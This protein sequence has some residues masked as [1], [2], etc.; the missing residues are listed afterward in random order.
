MLK[1]ETVFDSYICVSASPQNTINLEVPI[2]ALQR[3]LKSAFGA[4]SAQIRLTKKDN[5]PM[6]SLTIVTS[7]FAHGNGVVARPTVHNASGVD[8]E[9]G[10]FDFSL[11]FEEEGFGGSLRERETIVTQD[12]PVKVLTMQTV[13]GLLEPRTQ[14]PDVHIYL[15]NLAQV[16]SISERF[17]RL[18][19]TSKSGSSTASPRLELSANMHGSFK[20]AIKTDALAISSVWSGL[21]HPELDPTIY[22]NGTEG[23]QNHPSAKMKELGGPDGQNEAGWS[24]VRIDGKDWSRVL[25]V[26]RLSA[27]VI[28]CFINETGLILYVYLPSEEEGADESCLTVSLCQLVRSLF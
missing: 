26:G 4:S 8:E 16:K 15:P 22:E 18:S 10:E 21:T 9:F 20:I 14:E 13:E 27:R 7:S 5:V 28:A 25:S 2:Q 23:V 17:T 19:M 11:D 1:I 6:L 12:I 3:A 24:K